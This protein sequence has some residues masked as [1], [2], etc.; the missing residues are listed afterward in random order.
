PARLPAARCGSAEAGSCGKPRLKEEDGFAGRRAKAKPKQ[1][2]DALAKKWRGEFP[3]LAKKT[4]LISNSLGA[5]PARVYE[6]LR[7][8]ADTWARDGVLAWEEWLPMVTA[9]GD[10]IGRIIGA[11]PKSVMMHQ[12]VSTLTAIVISALDFRKGR[13]K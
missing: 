13:N 10:M 11:P 8:Y 7:E 1:S 6:R 5:M 12:N 2:M 3:I 9:T 4:Y